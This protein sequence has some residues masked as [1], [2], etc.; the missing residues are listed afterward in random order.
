VRSGIR[1]GLIG[2]GIAVP[3]ALVAARGL[4][5]ADLLFGVSPWDAATWFG[6]A[7]TLLTAVSFATLQPALRA[8]RV[9]PSHALR[10]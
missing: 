7:V 10:D 8:S 9:D 6:L 3:F 4:G 1:L 5:R 2:L